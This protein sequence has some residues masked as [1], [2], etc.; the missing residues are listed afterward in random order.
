MVFPHKLV[1]FPHH[2]LG[3]KWVEMNLSPLPRPGAG[4]MWASWVALTHRDGFCPAGL[5]QGWMPNLLFRLQWQCVMQLWLRD[6]IGFVNKVSRHICLC[7][8]LLAVSMIWE[9]FWNFLL[10]LPLIA[11]GYVVG[12]CPPWQIISCTS[13]QPVSPVELCCH[14]VWQHKK[15]W[16]HQKWFRTS[17]KLVTRK[18]EQ[19][20]KGLEISSDFDL[21]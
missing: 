8:L 4:V 1:R 3:K 16:L 10:L 18:H 14:H 5:S 6:Y 19:Y 13:P 12:M 17:S 9:N 20:L 21:D 2:L 7:L 11:G 15:H